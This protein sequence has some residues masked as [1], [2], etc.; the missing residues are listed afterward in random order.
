MN[1]KEITVLGYKCHDAHFLFHYMLQFAVKKTMKGKVVVPLFR[2]SVFLR[3]LWSKVINLD[4]LWKL[5]QSIVEVLCHFEMIFVYTFFD[6]IVHLLV[7][8][9][10]EVKLVGPEYLR[11]M[12]L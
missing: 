11:N 12:F 10:Q 2:F 3:G 6:I 8:L 1:T 5:Q 9:V 4:D 7:H